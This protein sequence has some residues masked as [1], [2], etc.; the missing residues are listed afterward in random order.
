MFRFGIFLNTFTCS[1]IIIFIGRFRGTQASNSMT[2][3]NCVRFFSRP[4]WCRC[5]FDV[6]PWVPSIVGRGTRG[7]LHL[8]GFLWGFRVVSYGF[9]GGDVVYVCIV[10][11]RDINFCTGKYRTISGVTGHH[12]FVV[13]VICVVVVTKLFCLFV[14]CTFKILSPFVV[15]VFVTVLLR[16]PMGCIVRGAG[17]PH[18]VISAITILLIIFIFKAVVKLVLSG[19]FSRLGSFF[20]C[21]VLRLSGTPLFTSRLGS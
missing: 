1:A 6:V 16:E 17:V 21:V 20:G 5:A 14:G 12:G 4:G 18:N 13:G 8:F 3:G 9:L 7:F 10:N 11:Q 2:R 15:T 19:V